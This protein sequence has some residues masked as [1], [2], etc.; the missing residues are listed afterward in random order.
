LNKRVL[1]LSAATAAV[2]AGPAL[3]AGPTTINTVQD[4]VVATST[5]GDLTINSGGGIKGGS[6]SAA[7]ITIDSS[8]TVLNAGVLTTSADTT[9][10]GYLIDASKNAVGSVDN[11]GNLSMTT[12]T[13]NK[14]LYL[15]VANGVG[16]FTGPIDF[17]SSSIV[18][19]VGDGSS[20]MYFD[21]GTTLNGD[22]TL[23]GTVTMTRQSNSS[24]STSSTG[25]TTSSISIAQFSGAINGNVTLGDGTTSSVLTAVGAG[26]QGV[27]V[28]GTINGCNTTK[29]PGCTEI[30]TLSNTSTLSVAGINQR[31]INSVNPESDAALIVGG[32]VAGGIVNDGPTVAGAATIAATISANGTTN[33]TVLIASQ[34]NATAPTVI[35][36]DTLDTNAPTAS[37]INRGSITATPVDPANAS[38]NLTRSMLIAG[39]TS[40]PVTFTG[41]FFNS[42]LISAAITTVTPAPNISGNITA[43]AIEI[44]NYVNI[45]N[46]HISGQAT[47]AFNGAGEVVASA[48]GTAGR[49]LAEAILIN[50]P[51]TYNGSSPPTVYTNV[52][53]ITIDANAS[54]IASA[55]FQPTVNDT[56]GR[57]ILALQA[58]AI[59]DSS[60]SLH[61]IDNAGTISA[62][63]TQNLPSGLVGIARAVDVSQDNTVGLLFNNSGTVIGDV[64]FG[65][66]N[67]IYT[68]AGGPSK[69]ATQTGE[70]NFSGGTD[71]LI[72]GSYS[73]VSGIILS[74]GSLSVSVAQNGVLTVQNVLDPSAPTN[75]NLT[76]TELDVA[77]ATGAATG[78]LNITVSQ[79]TVVG[80][81]V[82]NSTGPV[83]LGTGAN[84]GIKYGSFIPA[85]T[86][87]DGSSLFTLIAAPAGQMSISAVD[88]QR[89]Q[90][91]ISGANLPYL[92]STADLSKN[93][94]GA[95][96]LLQLLITPKNT[97][98][99]GITGYAKQMFPYA[100]IALAN[101][102]DLGAAMV[103]GINSKKDAQK[104]YD[105]FAPNASG[106]ERAIAISL[107]DQAT[108]VVAARLRELR[109]FAKESGDLTL[110]GHEFAE[111]LSNK[112][113]TT[114]SGDGLTTLNGYKDHGFGFSLGLDG[115]SPEGGWYGGAFTFYTGDVQEGGDRVSRLN[116]LWYMLTG[117]SEWRGRG[118]FFESQVNVGYASFKGKRFISL[119]IPGSPSTPTQA[120]I[121]ASTFTREA[122]SNRPGLV[123][124]IGAT[125]G[126]MLNYG[127]TKLIPQISLDGMTF[128]E[129]G[130]TEANGGEGFNLKVN[131]YYADS[132]RIFVGTEIREDLNLGDFL[133]QPSAR[134]G[135]RFDFLNNPVKLRAAFAD[136]DPA[137]LGNQPGQQFTVTGPDPG[138][139]N[140]VLGGALNTTTDNWTFGLN[141]DFVRG[142]N[143]ATQQIGTISL[144][145]R[146]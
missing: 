17:D 84:F 107:T 55:T 12:G 47:G 49:L 75:Q 101:D 63:V 137:T 72:V 46:I 141:Y 103:T 44:Q 100:N 7:L 15:S 58:G 69:L 53:K 48:S 78:T 65:A 118:L 133:L 104:A 117:Y 98:Q 38:V 145:G 102:N 108:G 28:L 90:Q 66:G 21:A 73:N 67:D 114:G 126:A 91:Q 23:A 143:N 57:N 62:T 87:T 45:P 59:I 18:K 88:I 125:A 97:T 4:K 37:F 30:G 54:V 113:Q 10:V 139:G 39:Q 135:Y 116:S 35:G 9:A 112:G 52:P 115:G 76:V 8:N 68:L 92:F 41:D 120:A 24:S 34:T 106:G 80:T 124:S 146:I 111:E 131:P 129:E 99:L 127:S 109:L 94:I 5:T 61:E 110:W 22:V 79:N 32:S 119:D 60:N 144:L 56:T 95:Q 29:V 64:F 2:L 130:Y 70:I 74:S 82:I 3:A 128:R 6:S 27:V 42:G 93:T 50:A 13:L 81:P 89:Y 83:T 142:S 86:A 16:S 33:P 14:G 134:V 31:S 123:G 77:G 136:V 36:I 85:S 19:I 138:Q 140:I 105:A 40:A 121:P 11:G 71:Q 51:A 132:L 25:T 96:D 20:A 1:M 26:A 122:D 43:T